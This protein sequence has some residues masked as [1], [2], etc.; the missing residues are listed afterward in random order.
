MGVQIFTNRRLL[1]F[2][3]S[4]K[5]LD[6]TI[7]QEKIHTRNDTTANDLVP[8]RDKSSF[9]GFRLGYIPDDCK[10]WIELQR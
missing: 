3:I 9:T 6:E 2:G 8:S 10:V 4:L 7:V 1:D 5:R